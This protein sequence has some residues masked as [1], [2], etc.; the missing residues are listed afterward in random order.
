MAR[1]PS[2]IDPPIAFG[3]RGARAHAQENTLDSF[4]L[5]LRLGAT[6]LESDV[7]RT[8]D[9]EVVLDHDGIVRS[10]VR[11]RPISEVARADLPRHIPTLAELYEAVGTDVPLSLDVKDTA[12]A[13]GIVAT[14]RDAGGHA[15]AYVWE[16]MAHAGADAADGNSM[17][18]YVEIRDGRTGE[19]LHGATAG[20]LW[21]HH[22]F[23]TGNGSLYEAG[24]ASYRRYSGEGTTDSMVFTIPTALGGGLATGPGGRELLIGAVEGGVYAFDPSV[25]DTAE[26]TYAPA[27][28]SSTVAGGGEMLAADLD[29]DGVTEVLSLNTD[30]TTSDRMAESIGGR[31]LTQDNA[32]H[33]VVTF[34]LS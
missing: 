8:A 11:R 15:V 16:I 6:G 20:G 23:F 33:Q 13:D 1:L 17:F 30:E 4:R 2:L 12:A 22:G 9:R 5:A 24:A 28:G 21:T 10:G 18:N 27:L 14:A 25:F 19:V 7:W 32:L 34:K 3:H 31:F 29:G 26:G